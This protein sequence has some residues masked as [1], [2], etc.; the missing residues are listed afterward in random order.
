MEKGSFM[1]FVGIEFGGRR[2]TASAVASATAA[3]E[4]SI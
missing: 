3:D 2:W 4:V 1:E